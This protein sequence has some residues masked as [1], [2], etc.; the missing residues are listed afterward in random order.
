MSDH[1][2]DHPEDVLGPMHGKRIETD[3]DTE[4]HARHSIGGRPRLDSAADDDIET[5]GEADTE[6]HRY[7]R[8]SIEDDGETEGHARR[9]P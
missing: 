5:D 3:G 2:S 4:G 6:G 8:F 1:R 7:H 9:K